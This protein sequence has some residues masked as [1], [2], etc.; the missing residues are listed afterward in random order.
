MI[1]SKYALHIPHQFYILLSKK[2]DNSI[3]LSFKFVPNFEQKT[4]HS[5]L[6]LY[7][8]SPELF[9]PLTFAVSIYTTGE[10]KKN[11]QNKTKQKT[12]APTNSSQTRPTNQ[13][14]AL[15]GCKNGKIIAASEPAWPCC[16]SFAENSDLR[17]PHWNIPDPHVFSALLLLICAAG[18]ILVSVFFFFCGFFKVLQ[19]NVCF[20]WQTFILILDTLQ[21]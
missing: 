10:E 4:S 13:M 18:L 6:S 8:F 17:V 9:W 12:K 11:H 2:V 21:F 15:A 20:L 3:I 19:R 7:I 1:S 14:K 16:S 5:I